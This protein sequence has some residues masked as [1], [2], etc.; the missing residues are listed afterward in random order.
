MF[1]YFGEEKRAKILEK[2]LGEKENKSCFLTVPQMI[3]QFPL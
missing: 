1:G 3:Q 2:G